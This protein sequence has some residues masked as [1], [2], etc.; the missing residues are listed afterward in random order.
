MQERRSSE[1][2]QVFAT[3]FELAP[4]QGFQLRLV[5]SSVLFSDWAQSPAFRQL[6][7]S[8]YEFAC[9]RQ[10]PEGLRSRRWEQKNRDS[11][12]IGREMLKTRSLPQRGTEDTGI[13][14]LSC[15]T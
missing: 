5:L 1:C 9:I 11:R 2:P 7:A 15:E 3:P 6:P 4:P 14:P 8:C 10:M 12:M 13:F